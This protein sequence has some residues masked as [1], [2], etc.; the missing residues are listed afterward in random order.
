MGLE[1]GEKK[2]CTWS[3][4]S[5]IYLHKNTDEC[6]S[7]TS[8]QTA[9]ALRRAGC[10]CRA[11]YGETPLLDSQGLHPWLRGCWGT[12]EGGTATERLKMVPRSS[13]PHLSQRCWQLLSCPLPSAPYPSELKNNP[14]HPHALRNPMGCS[15]GG[16]RTDGRCRPCAHRPCRAQGMGLRQSCEPAASW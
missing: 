14:L 1:Q 15:C 2:R 6:H 7:S 10:L 9:A 11:L 5:V 4:G 16:G 12:G 3:S 8:Q 13:C